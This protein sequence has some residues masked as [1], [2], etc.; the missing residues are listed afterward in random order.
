MFIEAISLYLLAHPHCCQF[1]PRKWTGNLH[2]FRHYAFRDN[3]NDIDIDEELA[4]S[5]ATAPR[6]MARSVSLL[7]GVSIIAGTMI[8]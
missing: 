1:W 8:G 4:F 5:A 2:I 6:K 7:G 3:H